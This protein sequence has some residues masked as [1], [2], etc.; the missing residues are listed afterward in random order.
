MPRSSSGLFP[1]GLYKLKLIFS[2][3]VY[4]RMMAFGEFVRIGEEVVLA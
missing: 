3:E 4:E 2:V 1:S